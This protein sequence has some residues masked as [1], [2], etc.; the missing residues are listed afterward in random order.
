MVG[1][2]GSDVGVSIEIPPVDACTVRVW[3]HGPEHEGAPVMH[4]LADVGAVSTSWLKVN[5]V[6]ASA[7]NAS[8]AAVTPPTVDGGSMFTVGADVQP[9]PGLVNVI[10]LM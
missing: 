9:E 4:D 8:A 1:A 2:G 6:V 7:R 10:A 5:E 3:N